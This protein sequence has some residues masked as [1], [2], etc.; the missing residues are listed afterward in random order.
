MEVHRIDLPRIVLIGRG[1]ID[2]LGEICREVGVERALIVTGKRTIQVAGERAQRVIHRQGIEAEIF[3]TENA[4]MATVE[5]VM[6][7]AQEVRAG[8]LIGVGGGRT[9]DVAKLASAQSGAH[10]ISVPTAASHDGIA[11][12]FASIRSLGK[13]YSVKARVPT[14]VVA[15]SQIVAESPHR[16]TASGCGDVVAKA[17]SVRDWRIAH[18]DL[19]EYYGDYAASLAQMSSEMVMQRAELIGGRS[20]E[21][22][23]ALLES[24]VSCG[25]AMSIAGSSRPCS[26]SEHLF[27]HAL[28][29][30]APSAVLHGEGCGLGTIMMAKLHGIDWVSIAEVLRKV[31]APTTAEEVGLTPNEVVEALVRAREVR[32]ERYT[33]LNRF[34]LTRERALS[35][36]MECGVI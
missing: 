25:V 23:R 10:F 18:E 13:P 12:G 2:K 4:D 22:Y 32:P 21:G 31:G 3:L 27:S 7:A 14:A 1:V 20:E 34:P 8:A 11:S 15:D 29:M 5:A 33:I 30:I 6:R 26:G 19:G 35:L 9:I 16:Y 17:V 28:E 36:A 24:L